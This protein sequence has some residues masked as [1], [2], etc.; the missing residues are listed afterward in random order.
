MKKFKRNAE[1]FDTLELFS[2]LASQYGYDLRDPATTD[3][4]A[5]KVEA[6]NE[7]RNATK[8]DFADKKNLI[9][10]SLRNCEKNNNGLG[11]LAA[12][13]RVCVKL[14]SS[15]RRYFQVKTAKGLI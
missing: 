4:F 2:N 8:R 3:D 1:V 6:N 13:S 7:D 15:L 10:V 11:L 5:N 9:H 14:S 12:N